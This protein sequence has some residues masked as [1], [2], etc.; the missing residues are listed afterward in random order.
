M[1]PNHIVTWTVC[2]SVLSVLIRSLWLSNGRDR[3]WVMVCLGVLAITLGTAVV[4]WPWIGWVSGSL[5]LLLIMIPLVGLRQVIRWMLQ[6][7]LGAAKRLAGAIAYLHPMDGWRSLVPLLSAL[8]LAQAGQ[9]AIALEQ[10]RPHLSSRHTLG[11][12][13]LVRIYALT[14]RWQALRHWLAQQPASVLH[15]SPWMVVYYLRTLGETE[16]LPTLLLTFEQCQPHLER[17]GDTQGLTLARMLV[18]AFT[19]QVDAITALFQQVPVDLSPHRQ[20]FWIATAQFAAGQPGIAHQ[21]LARITQPSPTLRQEI[22]WRQEH[23]PAPVGAIAP[24][25]IPQLMLDLQHEQDYGLRLSLFR[26]ASPATLVLI[27]LNCLMFGVATGA[28]GSQNLM[29]LYRLGAL[30]PEDV[31]NGAW[32][33]LVS[34]TFLHYG[35]L[36]LAMNMLGLWILGTYVETRLGL[37]RYSVAY[38]LTGIGSMGCVTLAAWISQAP[39]QIAVGASGAVM[40]MIGLITALLL[41]GWQTEKSRVAGQRLRVILLVIGLQVA[42]DLSTPGISVVGHLSGLILGFLL[43]LLLARSLQFRPIS[44]AS[45]EP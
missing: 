23:P 11:Y 7:R 28:G 34:A 10:V 39:S 38:L 2:L 21:T 45:T 25:L 24:P 22:R 26:R 29:V 31:I 8:Q 17:N 13:V 42:F 20:Q 3:G 14:G 37:W 16:D 32:W 41:Y 15:Q 40:G 19:G 12:L 6:D 44:L 5:W 27:G 18:L 36:H 9:D 30:V 1:T 43:G 33:R 35:G 4:A